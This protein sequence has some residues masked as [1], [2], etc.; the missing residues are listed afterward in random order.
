MVGVGSDPIPGVDITQRMDPRDV[1]GDG[2]FA[3]WIRVYRGWNWVVVPL[4]GN[5]RPLHAWEGYRETPEQY[6]ADLERWRADG[7]WHQASGIGLL[8]EFSDV[9]VFDVDVDEPD[10]YAHLS[11]VTGCEVTKDSVSH[12][13]SRTQSGQLHI[14]VDVSD[15]CGLIPT[16]SKKL[17][18]EIE[19]DSVEL[20]HHGACVPLPPTRTG[21]GRYEW[22]HE[23]RPDGD[24]LDSPHEWGITLIDRARNQIEE[25]RRETEERLVEQERQ[26]KAHERQVRAAQKR[27]EDVRLETGQEEAGRALKYQAEVPA[28][29]EGERTTA[30]TSLL[31]KLCKIGLSEHAVRSALEA[32][33]NRCQPPY[34]SEELA[35]SIFP[36]IAKYLN[37]QPKH[38]TG[39]GTRRVVSTQEVR[40]TPIDGTPTA[41]G[42][43]EISPLSDLAHQIEEDGDK[44]CEW[45][46]RYMEFSRTWS[47]RSYEEYHE[48][49]GLWLLS[50]V[51]ARRVYVGEGGKQ[52]TPLTVLLVGDSSRWKK[53]TVVNI[54]L[55][56]LAAAGLGHLR[57]ADTATPQKFLKDLEARFPRD[58]DELPAA[59]QERVRK[60]LAS[61]GQRGW[62]YEEFG[63][64]LKQM[65]RRDSVY[66]EFH[67][68]L[69]RL[70]DCPPSIEHGTLGRG[71]TYVERPYLALIGNLTNADLAP[72]AGKHD[73]MWHDGFWGRFVFY[74]VP[75]DAKP[76]RG[77]FPS[78]ERTY[79]PELLTPLKE[80]HKRLGEADVHIEE[81]KDKDGKPT[82]ERHVRV[83]ANE[84][85]ALR[86][87]DA[88]RE[89]F[90]TYDHSLQDITD[91][92]DHASLNANYTRLPMK[93]LR[94]AALFASLG[95]TDTIQRDHWG[96]AQQIVEGWRGSLHVVYDAMDVAPEQTRQ[97]IT[98]EA[99]ALK[100]IEEK[101]ALTA[102][103]I[104][105]LLH[106]PAT[107]A[108]ELLDKLKR[109]GE[110]EDVEVKAGNHRSKT[111][112]R[113]PTAGEEDKGKSA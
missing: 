76:G 92:W 95:G 52:Y 34:T 32:F 90:Y 50:T 45:L 73:A 77:R 8:T 67:A 65:T 27:G 61:A 93:A 98:A 111:M 108:G 87:D 66:N 110:V 2:R 62:Y 57:A 86:M 39:A 5:R 30:L 78:G 4:N 106:V 70:D 71:T 63:G 28:A 7:T 24:P 59:L 17:A 16:I 25:R 43:L 55:G 36:A 58:Y 102:R 107:E 22:I 37:Y 6:R 60:R 113:L 48:A 10:A 12:G 23:P 109:I 68:L 11:K 44:A 13:L 91:S 100:H 41:P 82:G 9:A 19:A 81:K 35:S 103:E 42:E 38:R 1:P 3:H 74:A 49:C 29:V 80:W 64:H 88:G 79:P 51:A 26:R 85:H 69:R 72:F 14:F 18:R 105:Q 46:D 15:Y 21:K 96:K 54:A 53:T 104:G 101:G 84:L 89:A 83:T 94:L 75:P 40:T 99:K 47:P 97:R 56:A 20:K 31:G 112:W 33:A